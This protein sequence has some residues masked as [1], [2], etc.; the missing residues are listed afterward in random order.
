MSAPS[1][2]PTAEGAAG[3]HARE[4]RGHTGRRAR[5][6]R[7]RRDRGIFRRDAGAR[8]HLRLRRRDPALRGLVEN[9]AYVSRADSGEPEN[10]VLRG[11]QVSALDLSRRARARD[12][13][14]SARAGS[15]CP[16]RCAMA[17]ASSSGARC[18]RARSDLLVET[19]PRGERLPRLLSVRG[20]PGAPDA[21]HAADAAAGARAARPLG[22]VANDYALA[23]WGARRR[24]AGIARGDC[25]SQSCSTRTCWATISKPGSPNPR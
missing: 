11:R 25:R 2:R 7:A 24:R 6:P 8:R 16:T 4:R 21:R 14:R 18:C 12:A 19:F 1:S 10:P 23:V 3:A 5:R 9:E 13:G 22:F 17:E 20:P 15:S